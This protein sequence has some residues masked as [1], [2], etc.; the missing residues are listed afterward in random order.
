M[1]CSSTFPICHPWCHHCSLAGKF[2]FLAHTGTWSSMLPPTTQPTIFTLKHQ[3]NWHPCVSRTHG[4]HC[5]MGN[6]AQASRLSSPRSRTIEQHSLKPVQEIRPQNSCCLKVWFSRAKL[7]V[8]SQ[9]YVPWSPCGTSGP[10]TPNNCKFS[11]PE[12]SWQQRHGT[13]LPKVHTRNP[14]LRPQLTK[15]LFPPWQKQVP[16][17]QVAQRQQASLKTL[18]AC[19]P[20]SPTSTAAVVSPWN[21]LPNGNRPGAPSALWEPDNSSP[22]ALMPHGYPQLA[23]QCQ[24]SAATHLSET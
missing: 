17:L 1:T 21:L 24:E 3:G 19:R 7:E 20:G 16:W 2:C 6:R 9:N 11:S 4:S 13:A 10:R 15:G 14:A 22:L 5:S 23:T 8:A 12:L 18:N